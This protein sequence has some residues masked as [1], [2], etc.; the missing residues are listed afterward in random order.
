MIDAAI[1]SELLKELE[2]LPPL[3][4]RKVV[5]FA[6]SLAESRPRGTP[7]DQLLRFAGTMTHEEA[8]EFLKAVNE[9]RSDPIIDQI[10]EVRHRISEEFGHDPKRLVE[11]YMKLQEEKYADRL[12]RPAKPETEASR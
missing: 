12:V 2:Q 9:T 3:L 5:D 1:Q 11:H 10:R 4:Q 6:H 7:G 8:Q